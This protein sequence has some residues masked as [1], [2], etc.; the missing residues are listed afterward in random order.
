MQKCT[1]TGI[2]RDSWLL[3]SLFG[4]IVCIR[5]SDSLKGYV[6]LFCFKRE[7]ESERTGEGEAEKES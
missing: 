4:D 3:L 1:G 6:F 7:W 5:T 2:F